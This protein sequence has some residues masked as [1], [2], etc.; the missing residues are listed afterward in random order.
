MKKSSR[1]DQSHALMK[2]RDPEKII[3]IGNMGHKQLGPQGE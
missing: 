3:T 1:D 2:S